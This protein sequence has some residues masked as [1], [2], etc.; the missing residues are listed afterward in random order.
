MDGYCPID[1]GTASRLSEFYKCFSDPTRV[2]LLHALSFRPMRVGEL[3][4]LSGVSLSAASHAL[5]LLRMSRLVA[6]EKQGKSVVYS[7]DDDHIK[8][9]FDMGL[10]HIAHR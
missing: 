6:Q 8:I 2:K 1:E 3:S 9:I 4:A 7:L 10:A 5:K